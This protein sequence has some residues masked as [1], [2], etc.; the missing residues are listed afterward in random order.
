MNSFSFI[1]GADA[2]CG[3]A[4]PNRGRLW[5][6]SMNSFSFIWCRCC[7]WFSFPYRGCLWALVYEF[8]F[9][10]LWCRSCLWCSTRSSPLV[11]HS[12][13][14]CLNIIYGADDVCGS[15]HPNC[16]RLWPLVYEFIF[17]Y[18]WCRCCLWS[19]SPLAPPPLATSL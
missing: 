9:I 3:P 4:L 18:L 16:S 1:S 11:G 8:I 14:L 2:V 7:L 17:I 6:L 13:N 12:T 10:Y 5:A 19:S 15:S